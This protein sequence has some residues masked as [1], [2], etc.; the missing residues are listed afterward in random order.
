MYRRSLIGS[1]ASAALLPGLLPGVGRAQ[2]FPSKQLRLLVG[3]KEL[4]EL[5]VD[6]QEI[7]DGMLVLNAVEPSLNDLAPVSVGGVERPFDEAEKIPGGSFVGAG[8][9]FRRHLASGD[10]VKDARPAVDPVPT[11][12]IS[13][14]F[15]EIEPSLF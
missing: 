3:G 13:G 9:G 8:L 10:A 12:K 14:D 7:P 4:F 1:A 11:R 6:R 5:D 15:L 2:S